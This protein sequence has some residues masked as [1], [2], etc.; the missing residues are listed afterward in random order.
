V[1]DLLDVLDLAS[2]NR[3]HLL[4]VEV[5]AERCSAQY[6][7]APIHGRTMQCD[8]LYR[9]WNT[10][11]E[12]RRGGFLYASGRPGCGKSATVRAAMR[13]FKSQYPRADAS[14]VNCME[15]QSGSRG[16]LAALLTAVR[17]KRPNSDA[18]N[19][20]LLRKYA[21]RNKEM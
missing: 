9:F 16:Q 12:Q 18:G 1:F 11:V 17:A 2:S 4:A 15:L 10:C 13:V 8:R 21:T 20:E 7:Y 14:F 19:D 5:A 6:A 3:W